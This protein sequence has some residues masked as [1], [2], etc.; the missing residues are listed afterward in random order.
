MSQAK[1]S[2]G[3]Y[4]VDVLLNSMPVVPGTDIGQ[5]AA[6]LVD[7]V[8]ALVSTANERIDAEAW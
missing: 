5:P 2:T 3:N 1:W 7:T 8:N 4:E 6:D